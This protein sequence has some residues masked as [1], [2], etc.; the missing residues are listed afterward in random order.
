MCLS[1][2]RVLW[3]SGTKGSV[4]RSTN[5]GNSWKAL[6]VKDFPRRDFRDIHAWSRRRAIAMS[7]GDSAVIVLT[8]NGGKSWNPV[9]ENHR[10]GI[11]LDGMDVSRRKGVCL[12]DPMP[13]S[14]DK[15][16]TRFLILITQ[17]AGNTWKEFWPELPV[18]PD[19]AA[20]AA[21]GSSVRYLAGKA[22]DGIVW[23]TGGGAEV[24][25]PEA[26]INHPGVMK[27]WSNI[28]LPLRGGSGWGAYT[29]CLQ[30]KHG[31]V[32]GGNYKEF[33]RRDS[34]AA[35]FNPENRHFEPAAEA[36]GGYRS[37]SCYNTRHRRYFCT[38]TNGTDIS[39]DLGA[40]WQPFSNTGG[41]V[42]VSEGNKLW[43]AANKGKIYRFRLAF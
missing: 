10:E 17:D 2:K 35:W 39:N 12:G 31:V 14:S 16:T 15:T 43:V 20:Y 6:P 34:I 8:R 22:D 26:E 5:G 36:P 38:G 3:V 33:N 21:S 11:F 30:L 42:C 29:M 32:L 37:G 13:V 1:S 40:R 18:Q 41:N 9:Y 19:E 24:R 4:F 25:M 28:A 7:S 23:I 27:S